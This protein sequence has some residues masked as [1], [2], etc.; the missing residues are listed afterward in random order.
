MNNIRVVNEFPMRKIP[1]PKTKIFPDA[2]Y[3]APVQGPA[4]CRLLH[5]EE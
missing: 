5:P 3:F 1:E 4:I 2:A